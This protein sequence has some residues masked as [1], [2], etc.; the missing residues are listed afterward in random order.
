MRIL[1]HLDNLRVGGAQHATID[2]AVGLEAR[3]HEVVLV[4]PHGPLAASARERGV[5]LRVLPADEAPSIRVVRA[6][7]DAAADLGAEVLVSFGDLAS[8]QAVAAAARHRVPVVTGHPANALP[9]AAPRSAVVVARRPAV[10]AAARRRN[11][12]VFD[13][14]SAVDTRHNHPDGDGSTFRTAHSEPGEALVVLVSRLSRVQKEAGLLLAVRAVTE[15]ARRRRVR[16]VVVGD[17]GMRAEVEEAARAAGGAVDVVGEL[18]D[19]RPAYAAA[20]VVLGLGTAA[21]RGMAHARPTVVLGEAGAAMVVGPETV[22]ELAAANWFAPGPPVTPEGLA[23]LVEALLDDP[24]RAARSGAAGRRAVESERSPTVV[25][26]ALEPALDAAVRRS[27][28]RLRYGVDAAR[29][30]SGR[31]L[32]LHARRLHRRTR[33]RLRRWSASRGWTTSS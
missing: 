15:L 21:L 25:A 18:V 4:A 8:T 5:A 33:H 10:L 26:A 32:R 3:G 1:L 2:L 31:W 9:A 14:P 17:G 23:G 20:D 19:P 27:P 16:L 29:S 6:L 12:A 28:S 7:A 30:W 24:E 13:V 11:P 22:D